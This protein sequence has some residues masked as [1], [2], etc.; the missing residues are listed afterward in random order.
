MFTKFNIQYPEFT[1]ITPQTGISYGIRALNVGDTDR[2]KSSITTPS[3][4]TE[5][6][7]KVLWNSLVSKPK[8][9]N[10]FEKWKEITTL[11]DREALMYGLYITSFPEEREFDLKCSTCSSDN[12]L[13]INIENMVEIAPYPGCQAMKE[14]YKFAR[15]NYEDDTPLDPEMEAILK[16]D[17]NDEMKK[18]VLEH[19]KQKSKKEQDVELI[20]FDDEDEEVDEKENNKKLEEEKNPTTILTTR[21]IIELPESK[22]VAV[23]KQP[24]IADEDII[25]KISPYGNKK[26]TDLINE[27]LVIER[28]EQY[29]LGNDIPSISLTDRREILRGY[30]QLPNKDKRYLFEKFRE[31]FGQYG[32]D[33]KASWECSDCGADNTLNLDIVTQFFRMVATN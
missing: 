13:K 19:T 21:K 24:T 18:K 12:H 16:K 26:N 7:N 14:Q 31:F 8:Q 6:I 20:N 1:V 9:I 29:E 4:A 25:L 10:D 17:K 2:L 11:R 27:T 22:I 23:L 3:K 15:E 32:I 30:Q 33:L 5:L 28:L